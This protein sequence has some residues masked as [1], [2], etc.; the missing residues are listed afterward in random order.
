MRYAKRTDTNHAEVR[1]NLRALGFDVLDLSK[2]GQGVPDLLVSRNGQGVLVEVK[3]PGGK[4]TAEQ[5]EFI[6]AMS[7]R[8]IVVETAAEVFN[9][10]ESRG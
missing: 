3:S 5:E 7:D 4:L 9:W 8:V 6:A 10:F 1:D 2:A